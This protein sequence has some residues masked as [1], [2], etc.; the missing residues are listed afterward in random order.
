MHPDTLAAW[1]VAH[2]PL[3][4]AV[5]V[6]LESMGLPV[7]GETTLVTAALVAGTGHGLHIGVVVAAAALG[8]IAGDSAGYWIGRRWGHA[9]LVRYGPLVRIDAARLRLGQYLFAR[10]G[11]K[12]VFFGRFVA[13]LRALAALLAGTNGMPWPRFFAFNAAGGVVWAAIFGFGAYTLGEG[14]THLQGRLAIAGIVLGVL[15]IVGGLWFV[16]RHEAALMREADRTFG[17]HSLAP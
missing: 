5:V 9:L 17:S 10:H 13:L 1:I 7:P 2:G 14:F 16:R 12:V 8:A 15:G 6:A 4:V 11:G 3:L